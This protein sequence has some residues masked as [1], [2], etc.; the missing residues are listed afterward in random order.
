MRQGP[1]IDRMNRQRTNAV[2][3]SLFSSCFYMT[4]Y[5]MLE[6]NPVLLLFPNVG[7]SRRPPGFF[8]HCPT[9]WREKAALRWANNTHTQQLAKEREIEG[10][11]VFPFRPDLTPWRNSFERGE[12]ERTRAHFASSFP[13]LS[14]HKAQ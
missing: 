7:D 5:K 12:R 9:T 2:V 3:R 4:I 13:W 10:W 11:S 8:P 1:S 14:A 6:R